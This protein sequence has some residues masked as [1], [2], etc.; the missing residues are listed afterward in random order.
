MSALSG[1][2]LGALIDDLG[3]ASAKRA[4]EVTKRTSFM[5]SGAQLGITVTGLLSTTGSAHC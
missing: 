1:A 4:L 5:L 2:G 3:D